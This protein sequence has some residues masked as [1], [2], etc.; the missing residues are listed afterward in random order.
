MK[1]MVFGT[2]DGLHPGH[3]SYFKQARKYG[4][5]LIAIV[6]L[7]ENVLQFKGHRPKFFQKHDQHEAKH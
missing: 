4:D 5:Y 1:V 2:F 3:L 6:A 7:D